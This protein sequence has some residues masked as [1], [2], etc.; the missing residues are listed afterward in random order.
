[1]GPTPTANLV[2]TAFEHNVLLPRA[3]P[4]MFLGSGGCA[5]LR[6]DDGMDAMRTCCA[7]LEVHQANVVVCVLT[8]PLEAKPQIRVPCIPANA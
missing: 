6:R 1:M 7:G 5:L 8:G 2:K 3:H 4:T